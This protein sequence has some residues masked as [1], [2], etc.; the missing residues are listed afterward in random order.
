MKRMWIASGILLSILAL[1]LWHSAHITRFTQEL[2]ALLEEAE[3][4]AEA[5][6]WAQAR[7][8]NEKAHKQWEDNDVY[9]HVLFRHDNTDAIFASFHEVEEFLECEEGGEYSAA[10][11][12]LIVQISLLAEAEQ[13]TL[14]NIL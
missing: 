2:T 5:G 1:T 11:A 3:Q 4:Y 12:K 13:L 10:N 8:Y 14:Q 9:L 6:D 7:Q